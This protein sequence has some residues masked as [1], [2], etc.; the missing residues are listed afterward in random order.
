MASSSHHH[1][2]AEP[3]N[4]WSD[5]QR[6]PSHS[7]EEPELVME[8][9]YTIEQ[10]SSSSPANSSNGGSPTRYSAQTIRQKKGRKLVS[11]M[12]SGS[13]HSD[14]TSSSTRTNSAE[15]DL[16][17]LSTMHGKQTTTTTSATNTISKTITTDKV[18]ENKASN[19]VT[20]K[21]AQRGFGQR[22]LFPSVGLYQGL[23]RVQAYSAMAFGSFALIHMVPPVLASVGGLNLADKAL[24][25][26]R[27]YY[28]VRRE[29]KTKKKA[30]HVESF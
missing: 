22:R 20:D 14:D 10:Q 16:P 9:L 27:V 11:T 1:P 3:Y 15:F 25:W 29:E 4:V 7:H 5:V 24:M 28:Q 2:A 8:E 26:G 21:E 6:P 18:E 30:D 13:T 23:G 17:E 12:R 19:S